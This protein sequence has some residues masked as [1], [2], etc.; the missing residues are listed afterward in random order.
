MG[1]RIN[2][3]FNS[4]NLG[5]KPKPVGFSALASNDVA[6]IKNYV[7]EG[8]KPGGIEDTFRLSSVMGKIQTP[9]DAEGFFAATQ[10][11]LGGLTKKSQAQRLEALQ[12]SVKSTQ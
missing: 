11:M 9:K 3:N 12:Q 10:R 1:L 6:R 2:N 7:Q 4:E 8:F 5:C